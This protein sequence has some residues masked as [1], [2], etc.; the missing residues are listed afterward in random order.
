MTSKGKDFQNHQMETGEIE[1]SSLEAL[2]HLQSPNET[3]GK[4][5][6]QQSMMLRE[7][8][9]GMKRLLQIF[10][11]QQNELVRFPDDLPTSF[12]NVEMEIAKCISGC[13]PD[14]PEQMRSVSQVQCLVRDYKVLVPVSGQNPTIS[15]HKFHLILQD[16]FQGSFFCQLMDLL[17]CDKFNTLSKVINFH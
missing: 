8:H 2:G 12:V 1:I 9:L 10:E 3:R 11:A 5:P 13:L 17:L 14:V 7:Y 4:N 6:Y 16:N 15:L